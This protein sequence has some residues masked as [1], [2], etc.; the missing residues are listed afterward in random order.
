MTR[1]PWARE[2][3]R[4]PNEYIWGLGPSEFARE[5]R[6]LL[7]P[8]ARVLELGC[9]EGRDSVFFATCGCEVT[10]VDVSAAGL[11]KAQELARAHGVEVRWVRAG[12]ARFAPA[13]SF[14]LVYSCG[15]IHYVPRRQRTRLFPR[16]QAL[17]RPGGY[18]A[19]VVFT[20]RHIYRE[21]SE[22]ID[23]FTDGEL[24]RAYADWLILR[25]EPVMITC[26]QD[27]TPHRH[28]VEQFIAKETDPCIVAVTLTGSDRRCR[29]SIQATPRLI[30]R[31]RRQLR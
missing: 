3:A 14:D 1:S 30:P 6:R 24:S 25:C 26:A 21:R 17:T 10:G 15:A 5:V 28:S 12:A 18:H 2:Y 8:G 20:D 9:G 22:L 23:Y 29:E 27:G 16:L 13:G 4:T 7:P 31:S 11:H 19:H